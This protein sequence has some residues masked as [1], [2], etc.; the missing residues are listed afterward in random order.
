MSS[1]QLVIQAQ[2]IM[3]SV[4][5]T[6]LG[7][8]GQTYMMKRPGNVNLYHVILTIGIQTQETIGSV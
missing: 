5:L 4:P 2:Y 7:Y 8:F 3:R 6:L 1:L